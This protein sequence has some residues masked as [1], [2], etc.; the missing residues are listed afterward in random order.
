MRILALALMVSW[1][2]G[3]NMSIKAGSVNADKPIIPQMSSNASRSYT[4]QLFHCIFCQKSKDGGIL[5]SNTHK[6]V[7]MILLVPYARVVPSIWEG[8]TNLSA[9]NSDD[10]I[11]RKKIASSNPF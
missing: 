8:A 5:I 9:S 11:D 10:I 4:V 6:L 7:N 3:S 2:Y 1:S